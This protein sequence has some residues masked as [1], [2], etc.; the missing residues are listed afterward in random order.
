VGHTKTGAAAFGYAADMQQ[1]LRQPTGPPT[2]GIAGSL[3]ESRHFPVTNATG[4]GRTVKLLG[5]LSNA[6][7]VGPQYVSEHWRTLPN[8]A[9]TSEG[10]EFESLRAHAAQKCFPSSGRRRCRDF[11]DSFDDTSHYVRARFAGLSSESMPATAERGRAVLRGRGVGHGPLAVIG[12]GNW[13][14]RVRGPRRCRPCRRRGPDRP[15]AGRGCR[16]GC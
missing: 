8:G 13:R 11:D 14:L 1:A 15:C 5:G 4:Q 2:R 10:W 12:C 3:C 7:P 16:C 6:Y 9:N